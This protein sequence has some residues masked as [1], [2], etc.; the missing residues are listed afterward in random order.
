M[1]DPS[2]SLAANGGSASYGATHGT[3]SHGEDAGSADELQRSLLARD[4]HTAPHAQ[5]GHTDAAH[6]HAHGHDS[7]SHKHGHGGEHEHEHAHWFGEAGL[8]RRPQLLVDWMAD[9]EKGA[10]KDEG[11]ERHISWSE[12][13]GIDGAALCFYREWGL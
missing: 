13:R 7:H 6:G 8:C 9:G 11:E 1:A 12:V 4:E 10:R 3:H 5:P 2:R